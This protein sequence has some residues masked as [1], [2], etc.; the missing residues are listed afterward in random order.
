MSYFI[1]PNNTNNIE[2]NTFAPFTNY[3]IDQTETEI[4]DSTIISH[5]LYNYYN[6]I[7]S[8]LLHLTYKGYEHQ[9]QD[10]TDHDNHEQEDINQ[11]NSMDEKFQFLIKIMHPFEQIDTITKIN[12]NITTAPNVLINKPQ[13]YHLKQHYNILFYDMIEI[14]QSHNLLLIFAELPFIK[15][16]HIGPKLI[17]NYQYLSHI[18]NNP[19]DKYF[20][21]YEDT[22]ADL[23]YLFHYIFYDIIDDI[24]TTA[25]ATTTIATTNTTINEKDMKKYVIQFVKAI[26][27]ILKCQMAGGICVI[28][29]THIFYKPIIDFIYM[30]TILYEKVMIVK[31]STSNPILFDKYI[32]CKGFIGKNT[33]KYYSDLNEWYSYFISSNNAIVAVEPPPDNPHNDNTSTSKTEHHFSPI[34][35]IIPLYFLNKLNDINIILGQKQLDVLDQ[36]IYILKNKYMDNKIELIRKQNMQTCSL[37]CKKYKLFSIFLLFRKFT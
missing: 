26:M 13:T 27:F 12:L 4:Y 8:Q 1:L 23:N 21:F 36:L 3:N 24:T 22:G 10:Q 5:S 30:L 31:P 14:I 6:I 7:K 28:K 2:I 11:Y 35:N 9:K 34:K 33:E 37:W 25:A 15:A 32:V 20:Y 17:E 29:I 19:L 18:R 16:I